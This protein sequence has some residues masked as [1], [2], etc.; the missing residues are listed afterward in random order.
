MFPEFARNNSKGQV[1]MQENRFDKAAL[2]WDD[3]P[4]RVEMAKHFATAIED[5]IP[6]DSNMQVMD[7]GCGTGNV[8][9]RLSPL[10]G[11][12]TAVDSSAGMIS[13][14]EKKLAGSDLKNIKPFLAEFDEDNFRNASFDLIYSCMTF[15]H[16]EDIEHVL[17]LFY[18]MLNPCGYLVLIDL[19][20]EDGS[21]HDDNTGVVHFGFD[22]ELLN[23]TLDEIGFTDI[24]SRTAYTRVKTLPSGISREYPIFLITGM[25]SIG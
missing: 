1:Y 25:K 16:I 15:H 11:T 21:F 18:K 24:Y 8:A 4:E 20:K 23:H 9:V 2:N 12:I 17:R 3:A 14:L 7:F 19:A 10:V 13:M 6:L 5:I 22:Q